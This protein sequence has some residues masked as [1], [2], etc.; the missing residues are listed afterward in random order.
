MSPELQIFL[1]IIVG[2]AAVYFMLVIGNLRIGKRY[3]QWWCPPAAF[4]LM[5]YCIFEYFDTIRQAEIAL[6]SS[7]VTLQNAILRARAVLL[8]NIGLGLD[9]A[10]FSLII[11]VIYAIV[12]LGLL[13][14]GNLLR[15]RKKN[16]TENTPEYVPK[17]SPAYKVDNQNMAVLRKEW[18]FPLLFLEYFMWFSI[19]V[20]LLTTLLALLD[21]FTQTNIPVPA[22]SAFSL[23]V[24]LETYWYLQHTRIEQEALPPIET[25]P[26]VTSVDFYPLWE[27]Y[28]RIWFDKV[29]LA[30][31]YQSSQPEINTPTAV[32]ITEARNL[33]NAGYSLSVNDYHIIER[34]SNRE[35][36][37]I[38][39]MVSDQVAPLLFAVFL[40]R[41][42]DG[43]NILVLTAK[44]CYANSQYHQ[45]IAQWIN[46]WFFKLTTNRDFWKVQVYSRT[47]DV[48]LSARIIIT[49]AEDILEKN[50]VGHA[51]FGRLRT[52]LF[53]NGDE[54][55]TE[56]LA[57]NNIV[58]ETLRDKYKNIQSVVL[59]EY[60]EALQSSVMRNLSVKSDM[61]EVRLRPSPPPKTFVI[62]WRLEGETLFQHKVLS[63]HIEKFLGAEAVLALLARRERIAPIQM[64]GQEDLPYYEYLEELDNNAESLLT[65]PVAARTLKYKGVSEV[66]HNETNFLMQP[67]LNNFVLARDNEHNLPVACR[68]W[69]AHAQNSVFVHVVCPPYLLRD[70]FIDNIEY[71]SRTP[72]YAL[73]SKMM[74]SRFE[75]ARML[76]ERMVSQELS[77]T[78]ILEELNWINPNAVFIKHELSELFRLAFGIDIIASNYLEIKSVYEFDRADDSYKKITKYRLLPRIKDD[79][80]LNFLRNVEIIDQSRNV[81]QVISGDLLFQN[82]LPNQ[83]HAFN[84]KSYSIMGY[85]KLNRKLL[86]NHRSPEPI[87]AY[88]PDLA[89]HIT[90][91]DEPLTESQRK[92][93][94][95]DLGITLCEGAFEVQ[96]K[97]Y[98]TFKTGF[99]LQKNGYVYTNTSPTEVPMRQYSLGRMAT[100][101]I[102]VDDKDS[103]KKL[104][105]PRITATLTVLLHEVFFTLFPE[106]HQYI[107]VGSPVNN[108][109]FKGQFAQL[110]PSVAIKGMQPD[111]KQRVVVLLFLEDS[112]QDLGLVQSIFDKWDYIF[113]VADDYLTWLTDGQEANP[114]VQNNTPTANKQSD[115]QPIFRKVK[116]DKFQ[117]LKYGY[118]AVPDF[119]DLQGTS[120]L[121]KQ[122]LGKNFLSSERTGF[123]KK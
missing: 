87:V 2:A 35:D 30:W 23:L 43:E 39:D 46:D 51:W 119:L 74:V 9:E 76:L 10:A 27:E 96:T 22:L 106:T 54:I 84:G 4:L 24:V 95:E 121:L 68:R 57:A 42:M 101:M 14:G 117:F 3:K 49:S 120:I 82:Y 104:D 13:E 85:D 36:L 122:L 118:E 12:R 62:Y 15:G 110:Y 116:F 105:V 1:L 109:L 44:R 59:S 67:A 48:E 77:E 91:M 108:L 5:C 16:Q 64:T 66:L 89:V 55:F 79:L 37:L 103:E 61:K 83:T 115:A 6:V 97:G 38:D 25:A 111:L 75:V 58:L 72:L 45:Q 34:L 29:A 31:H 26:K 65:T 47:E 19:G 28:Q 114:L 63:G 60:R 99:G 18:V 56:S 113:R 40:R 94:G 112:F 93:F 32:Q 78:D 92:D 123:Y 17:W 11:I 7:N 81:L 41:L 8:E 90:Q 21:A 73:S 88:R 80:S 20:F 70:Y 100:M 33:L 102:N 71:F 53:L 50:V 52:V 107:V 86:T 98:F 69:E